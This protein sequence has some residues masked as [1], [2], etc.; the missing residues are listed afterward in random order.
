MLQTKLKKDKI[1][2]QYKKRCAR[3][4]TKRAQYRYQVTKTLS[5]KWKP[6][7]W[8]KGFSI[9]TDVCPQRYN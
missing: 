4:K 3:L 1:E 7:V 6:T 8:N 5:N 2:E 9:L